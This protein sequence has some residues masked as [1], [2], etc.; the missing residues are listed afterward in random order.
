MDKI[1]PTYEVSGDWLLKIKE[2]AERAQN[3][4]VAYSFDR[5]EMAEEAIVKMMADAKIIRDEVW[6][7]LFVEADD[8]D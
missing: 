6:R 3:P 8:V 4:Q 2:L 5:V 7:M 1:K